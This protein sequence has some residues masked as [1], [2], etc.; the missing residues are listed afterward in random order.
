MQT[1]AGMYSD[2]KKLHKSSVEFEDC[3]QMDN[4]QMNRLNARIGKLQDESIVCL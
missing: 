3:Q 2:K 1:E 4:T